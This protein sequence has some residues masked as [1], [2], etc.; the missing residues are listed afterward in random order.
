MVGKACLH[1]K[2]RKVGVFLRR[3][4]PQTLIED[5]K[6]DAAVQDCT[7]TA[8][9]ELLNASTP[10]YSISALLAASSVVDE[11]V[12][13][14]EARDVRINVGNVARNAG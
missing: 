6:I 10:S 7:L 12:K 1:G 2:K 9:V 4:N 11:N 8:V 13:D 14:G 5:A 3:R